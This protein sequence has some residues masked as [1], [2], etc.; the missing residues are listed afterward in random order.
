[1]GNVLVV[2]TGTIGRPVAGLMEKAAEELGISGLAVHKNSPQEET[3]GTV[4]R[5]IGRGRV[6]L[7]TEEDTVD[8]FK[9]WGLVPKMI[10]PEALA[11]A[12]VVVD[13]T[14]YGNAHK[15]GRA[16]SKR[17]EVI[18]MDPWYP[19]HEEHVTGFIAQGSEADFG[20]PYAL[21]I[22]DEQTAGQKWIQVVSCNTH[23]LSVIVDTLRGM[24]LEILDGDFTAIR[25]CTD[26]S[27][28]SMIASP[29]V[30]AHKDPRFGT[31]HA[32]DAW[33]VYQTMGLD[34]PLFSSSM[35]VPT[36]YMHVIRF[37][38][39]VSDP[40]TRDKVVEAF[41]ARPY[42]AITQRVTA[43]QIFSEARDSGFNGRILDQTVVAVKT[44]SVIGDHIVGYCF[45]PQDGNSLLTTMAA[46]ARFL[47]PEG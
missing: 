7:V 21:G 39:Q 6:Q 26:I 4:Q 5:I 23:N 25:R 35:Q 14:P 8:A 30:D 17:G 42:V 11:W 45:T 34:L 15:T 1:M 9:Q 16:V 19:D 18:E 43:E 38:I 27:Q 32:K 40:P 12:D 24:G 44:I 20:I 37:R 46:T 10:R 13:C 29:K 41:R 47:D 2:G 28:A 33:R 22:N 3:V 31:H 36:Q